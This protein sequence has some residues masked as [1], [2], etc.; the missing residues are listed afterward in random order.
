MRRVVR[1]YIA[2]AIDRA[3]PEL[4]RYIAGHLQAGGRPRSY[5][6]DPLV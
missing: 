3:R 6:T 4:E 2:A 1:D 5:F